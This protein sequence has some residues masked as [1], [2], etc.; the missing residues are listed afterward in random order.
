MANNIDYFM[1]NPQEKWHGFN[2]YGEKQY[3]LDP[4]K[5][6]I[7]TPGIN[8]EKK[9]YEDFGIPSIILMNYLRENLI[10]PEKCEAYNILFLLTPAESFVI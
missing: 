4:C 3:F 9:E 1:I 2:G 8:A 7:I 6:N 5:L 10:I